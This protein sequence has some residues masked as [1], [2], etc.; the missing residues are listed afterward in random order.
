MKPDVY[1]SV[2]E[3]A[4]AYRT[5]ETTASATVESLLDSIESH[6]QKLGAFQSVYADDAR[7]AAEAA[8]QAMRT[9]HRIGPFH[10]I[11]SPSRTSWTW[12]VA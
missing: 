10:G 3:T 6:D 7:A 2:L 5:G 8:D 1:P 11:P 9:G 4:R 12:R